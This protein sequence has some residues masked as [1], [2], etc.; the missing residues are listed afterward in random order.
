MKKSKNFVRVIT[1]DLTFSIFGCLVELWNYRELLLTLSWREIKIRYKQTVLGVFWAV[2]QPTSLTII[3][4]IIF[5]KFAHIPTEGIPYPI[6]AYSALLPWTFFSTALTFAVPSMVRERHLLMKV[7]FPRE[8]SPLSSVLAPL[9][10]FGI[11]VLVFAAMM[12]YYNIGVT[13]HILWVLPLLS[14]QL[15]FTVGI[16]LF[17]AAV[18]ARY[19]DV[20]YAVPLFLQLWMFATPIFYPVT[21]IPENYRMLYML[22]PMASI[23]DGYRRVII[24]G[25]RPELR[26]ILLSALVSLVLFLLSYAYFKRAERKFMD[27]I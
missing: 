5:G 26:Y 21:F 6:F 16:S 7:Y 18:N 17:F 15:I 14:L 23:I 20:R 19:R 27:V 13:W 24:K 3:F 4:S 9:V 1:P 25:V 10:D 2:A 12:L 11:T 22:N 8:I